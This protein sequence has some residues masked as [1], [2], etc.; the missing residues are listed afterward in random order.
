MNTLNLFSLIA[1][2][3]K[4][5]RAP[6][7]IGGAVAMAA[8]GFARETSDLDVF[9]HGDD[10][11]RVL[12]ALRKAGLKIATI[13]EPY[14]YAIFPDLTDP[15]TRIDLLFAWSEPEVSAI[16]AP[17]ELD[18]TIMGEEMTVNVFP[19]VLIA[20]AKLVSDRVRDHQDVAAMYVRGLFDPTE[21]KT[22][23]K[24]LKDKDA[25]QRLRDLT[26]SQR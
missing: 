12:S 7:A 2:P 10:S 16:D 24:H 19:V 8:H 21:V 6:Y 4:K 3:I 15:D 5:S 25:T 14:H 23:L 26:R 9:F 11:N 13:A 1:D 22:I 20:T 17:D 18:A